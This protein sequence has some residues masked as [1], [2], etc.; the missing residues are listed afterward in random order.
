MRLRR[1]PRLLPRPLT[2]AP[3]ARKM[4]PWHRRRGRNVSRSCVAGNESQT[5]KQSNAQSA[6]MT[7]GVVAARPGRNNDSNRSSSSRNRRSRRS[8]CRRLTKLKSGRRGRRNCF[9][10][11]WI[12]MATIGLRCLKLWAPVRPSKSRITFTIIGR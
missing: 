7:A 2:P 5:T 6:G 12:S 9:T 10:T 8:S 4:N 11:H 3:Q 1:G